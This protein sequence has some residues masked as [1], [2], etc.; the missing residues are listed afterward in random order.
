MSFAQN[1]RKIPAQGKLVFERRPGCA[2]FITSALLRAAQSL[3]SPFVSPLK[4][5]EVAT[6]ADPGRRYA[7]DAASLCP[8]LICDGLSGR[9][10]NV[11]A[12]L[13]R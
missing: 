4:G 6:H 10:T 3:I 9:E 2:G 11:V 5:L 12:T 13:R 1:G 8:G 7:A